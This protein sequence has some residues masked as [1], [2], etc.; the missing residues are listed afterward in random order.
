MSVPVGW[1]LSQSDLSIR[2]RGGGTGL[3]R[4][5][6]LVLTTELEKPFRW[7]SGGELVLTTGMRLPAT[8][9]ARAGY[10]R[11]F[12]ESGVAAV[13]FG[14]GL[15]HADVP[16]DLV[17]VADELGIPLLEVPL[18]TAFAAVV[19]RV[20][21]RVAEL[22]YDTVLRASRAQPRMTR[23]LI[24]AGAPAVVRELATSLG[25]MV[26]V[27]DPAG[28]LLDSH[29][30]APV[31]EVLDIVRGTLAAGPAAAAGS[32]HTATTGHSITSQRISVGS[33]WYGDLVVVG[34]APL[35]SVDQILLG[36]ANSLLALDFEKPARLRA[37]QHRL[38]STALALLLHT[39]ADP[40]PARALL[41]QAAD[42]DGRIRVLAVDCDTAESVVRMR[43]AVEDIAAVAGHPPFVHVVD[44]RLLTVL[45]G[46][47]ALP[48]AHRLLAEIDPATRKS[49]R[50]GVSDD[51]GPAELTAAVRAAELAA[52]AA[53]RGGAPAEFGVLSGRSL[54]AFETTR[55]ALDA[56]GEAVLKPLI[57]YDRAQ[58]SEL[59]AALHAY[60]EANGQ[61]EAAAAALGVHRHTLRKR[62][63]ACADLLDCDLDNARIRAELLLALLVRRG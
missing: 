56:M 21:A 26:L 55:R 10:L 49:L 23:A 53:E 50:A 16:A 33:R 6:D 5:I 45:P 38:N 32:V 41:A 46:A 1:V 3:G 58:G 40:A 19:K 59:T 63:A 47:A 8:A 14:T 7:L 57:E 30:V 43:A 61:W 62:I 13:G 52:S 9:A 2:L 51:H 15:S 28:R 29:P 60:L 18:E 37:D 36:H 17:A 27:F 24:R 4:T 12:A 31:R 35:G 22:Q 11:G 39:D 44:R 25:A 34:A 54:L 20:T 48:L 42:A